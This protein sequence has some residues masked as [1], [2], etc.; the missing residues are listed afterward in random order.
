[1]RHAFAIVLAVLV[2]ALPARAAEGDA[3]P[4]NKRAP[5][6]AGNLAVNPHD[7]IAVYRPSDQAGV[8]V[9]IGR[10]GQAIQ[11]IVFKDAREAAE[12]FNGLWNNDDITKNPGDDDTRPLTRMLPKTAERKNA[13]LILNIPRV[14]AVSWES[15]RRGLHVYLDKPMVAVLVEPN[16]GEERAHIE[17]ENVRDDGDSIMAAYKLC[18]VGK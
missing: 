15:N 5:V 6:V 9:Y 4:A 11:T 17:I 3:G 10:P 8:A 16:T 13:I 18:L 12:V 2:T 7:I 1:M 14:L